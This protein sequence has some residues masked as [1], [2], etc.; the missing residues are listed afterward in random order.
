MGHKLHDPEFLKATGGVLD[1]HPM[2]HQ[3]RG[4]M[5]RPVVL[6]FTFQKSRCRFL[7]LVLSFVLPSLS[8]VV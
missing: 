8:C 3:V 2:Y 5:P 6:V 7:L 1:C 4:T